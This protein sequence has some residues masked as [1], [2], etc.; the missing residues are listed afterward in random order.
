MAG[1]RQPPEDSKKWAD[2]AH[3]M[4]T[5]VVLICRRCKKKIE[6]WHCAESG[7]PWCAK[8]GEDA[9]IKAK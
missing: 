4:K 9:K 7:C 6:L 5:P 3:E 1:Q 2:M 8:C